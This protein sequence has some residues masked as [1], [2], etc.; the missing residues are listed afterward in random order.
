MPARVW[1][2]SSK[3]ASMSPYAEHTIAYLLVYFYRSIA[4]RPS[5]RSGLVFFRVSMPANRAIALAHYQPEP[6][7]AGQVDR[8]QCTLIILNFKAIELTR[9][10]GYVII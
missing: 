8:P 1:A 3:T 2:Y 5:C 4:K 6:T 9:G 10:I 7:C